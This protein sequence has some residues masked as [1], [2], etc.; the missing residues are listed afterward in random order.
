MTQ[1]QM[2]DESSSREDVCDNDDEMLID[3]DDISGVINDSK[4]NENSCSDGGHNNMPP[5][6]SSDKDLFKAPDMSDVVVKRPD[7]PHAASPGSAGCSL[8]IYNNGS[9][10]TSNVVL[11]NNDTIQENSQQ[12]SQNEHSEGNSE[13][14]SL[15]LSQS[16][17]NVNGIEHES[18]NS[19][20]IVSGE[21]QGENQ[22][23]VNQL[24]HKNGDR[25]NEEMSLQLSLENRDISTNDQITEN[26]DSN[27]N[28]SSGGNSSSNINNNSNNNDKSHAI[29]QISQLEID[30]ESEYQIANMAEIAVRD[31][32]IPQQKDQMLLVSQSQSIENT[33][34]LILSTPI[35]KSTGEG[36]IAKYGIRQLM[37]YIFEKLAFNKL[38][39]NMRAVEINVLPAKNEESGE[40]NEINSSLT[41]PH[42]SISQPTSTHEKVQNN[43]GENVVICIN[44][45]NIDSQGMISL[46]YVSSAY[47]ESQSQAKIASVI[48]R[49]TKIYQKKGHLVEKDAVV[50]APLKVTQPGELDRQNIK[51]I[52]SSLTPTN[53]DGTP[54]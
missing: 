28:S 51:C 2:D 4:N 24:N 3:E 47:E 17:K 15:F 41:Q 54:S 7:K 35:N 42:L 26:S 49:N 43:V 16:Q 19:K 48:A 52:E 40:N 44:H 13:E 39:K 50:S 11:L 25:E 1:I 30:H 14:L 34:N 9:T 53:R 38:K 5:M 8:G 37:A 45:N 21:N 46:S 10:T 12:Q 27:G 23:M 29:S 22:E 32:T 31:E 18:N 33:P 6:K 36:G 20:G